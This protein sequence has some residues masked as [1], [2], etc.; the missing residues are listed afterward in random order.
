[1]SYTNGFQAFN[2]VGDTIGNGDGTWAAAT[3][4]GTENFLFI[5]SNQFNGG[6][7]NDCTEGGAF[8]MR[9]NMFNGATLTSQTH[10]T[11]SPG[12]P[13]R[14][15]RAFEHYHNYVQGLAGAQP[16]DGCSVPRAARRSS[17][18]IP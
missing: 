14:G 4:W 15:C 10:A 11:K 6:Y 3:P 1:M 9:Y 18:A 5:E 8:V 16:L 2:A 17:G 7:A 13:G 12:G